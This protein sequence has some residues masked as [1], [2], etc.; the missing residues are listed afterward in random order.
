MRSILLRDDQPAVLVLGHFAPQLQGIHGFAGPEQLHTLVAQFYDVPH[1]SSKGLLYQ[2]YVHNPSLAAETY[3]IDPVL[4]N[5]AGHQVLADTL[6]HYFQTQICAAW[7]AANGY[8]FD[9]PIPSFDASGAGEA[10]DAKGLFGGMGIRKGEAAAEEVAKGSPPA[11]LVDEPAF[12]VPPFL[13][14]TRPT[15]GGGS[16]SYRFTEISPF[17][18][19]A[20]DLINP[21]PPSLF[22][23]SGWHAF[24]PK[25]SAGDAQLEAG[26]HYWYSTYPTS[27]LRVPIKIRGGD[28]AIWYMTEARGRPS[29]AISCWVDNN[30]AGAAIIDSAGQGDSPAPV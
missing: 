15:I 2:D 26:S 3:F 5:T 24:K 6:I 16:D 4:P 25:A 17:C 13:L 19:S 11:H 9:V 10:A 30:Y 1:I 20:N 22:Y 21:L 14:S 18:V 27:K 29:S 23:G 28:V 12:Q 7:S 8:S